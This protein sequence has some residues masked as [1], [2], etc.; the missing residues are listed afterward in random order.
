MIYKTV[1]FRRA[2]EKAARVNLETHLKE[3]REIQVQP[4]KVHVDL[5][6]SSNAV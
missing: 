2:Y 3:M 6:E 5:K 4:I 1:C